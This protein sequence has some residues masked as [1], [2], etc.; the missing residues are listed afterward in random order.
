[1]SEPWHGYL[2]TLNCGHMQLTD[3]ADRRVGQ[4][5]TCDLCPLNVHDE[6]SPGR[7]VRSVRLIVRIGPAR[8]PQEPDDWGP[9]YW[10]GT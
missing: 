3:L 8:A 6:S 1:M 9:Q 10:Y 7:P 5:V 4:L 2:E